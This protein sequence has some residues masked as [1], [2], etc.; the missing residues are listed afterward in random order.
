MMMIFKIYIIYN[1]FTFHSCQALENLIV[2]QL[3]YQGQILVKQAWHIWGKPVE[4]I[5]LIQ[6][7]VIL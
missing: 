1:L 7:K 5:Y 4:V 6:Y 3:S 2:N